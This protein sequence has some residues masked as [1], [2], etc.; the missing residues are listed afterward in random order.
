[1]MKFIY[2]TSY[3]VCYRPTEYM[4]MDGFIHLQYYDLLLF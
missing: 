1:M 2:K 3:S 4:M